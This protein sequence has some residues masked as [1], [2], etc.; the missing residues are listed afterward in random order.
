MRTHFKVGDRVKTFSVPI[1]SPI[2]SAQSGGG[3][4]IPNK[5]LEISNIHYYD[6][7]NVMY[8]KG[9]PGPIFEGNFS[10]C[11][12]G[13]IVGDKVRI[14]ADIREG[15]LDDIYIT[16]FATQFRNREVIIQ[17]LSN[18]HQIFLAE[19]FTWPISAIEFSKNKTLEIW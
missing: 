3:G 10:L 8:F 6:S 14:R 9:H 11:P 18:D 15:M 16:S 4:F 17:Y 1:I 13:L 12:D 5:V 19:G 7:H 2:S